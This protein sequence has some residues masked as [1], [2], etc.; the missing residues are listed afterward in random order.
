MTTL[1]DHAL[2]LAAA[3]F[4]V[5]PLEAGTKVP[6]IDAYPKRATR[7]PEQIRR[8][9]TCPVMGTL[10][11]Y[12]IGISTDRWQAPDGTI[13][14]PVVLDVDA[15]D[16]KPGHE[17]LLAHELAGRGSP[18]TWTGGTP[19]SGQHLFYL[20][21][22]P[23]TQGAEVL[24]PGLD[25]R[26]RG[27]YIVGPG[28][29]VTAGVYAALDNRAPVPAP[30]WVLAMCAPAR[31]RAPAQ[32]PAA[33]VDLERAM[34]RAVAY[35]ENEAPLALE[36]AGGDDTAYRVACRV[37][38]LGL[39]EPG[40]LEAMLDH[41]NDRCSPPWSPEELETK[42]A[43]AYRYGQEPVGA[44]APEAQFPPEPE[45]EGQEEETLSP[46]EALNREYAVCLVSGAHNVIRETTDE[47]GRFKL[48][49][50]VEPS[51]HKL[52]ATRP[53]MEIGGK[54][55]PLTKVWMT[56]PRRRTYEGVAFVPGRKARPGW[57]NLWR[58]FA[59]EPLR[60]GE[61]APAEW[62]AAVDMWLEH[63][64]E[65]I[66]QGNRQLFQWLIGW[67][68][69]IIQ[70]P[71]EKPQTALVLRGG[72]GT[73]KNVWIER[74]IKLLG[75]HGLVAADR[76]YLVGNFNAHLE[77]LLAFVLDEAFWSG[78]KAIEG[79]LKALVTGAT[80]LIERKGREPYVVDNLLRLI[81]LG[82]DDWLVQASVDER[83]WAAFSM[84]TKRQQDRAF[85][86]R[87]IS[88]MDAGG[89]RLLLRCL[90]DWK[91][92][93]DINVAPATKALVEQKLASLDP[94]H[95]WWLDSLEEGRIQG[96]DFAEG[97]QERMSTESVREAFRRYFRNRHIRSRLPEDRV[98]GKRLLEC[99]PAIR[100]ARGSTGYDYVLP[101]LDRAWA[102][103]K[104]FIG[105]DF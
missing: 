3:G 19:T 36:G 22:H 71:W 53:P 92:D 89:D 9:W 1:L 73:G 75:V 47:Q 43:N 84:G 86:G 14:C 11:P 59:V 76:R 48:D 8:W 17:T 13:H 33:E 5:F 29:E 12:N 42:V 49:Y 25:V 15:K 103:W 87:M 23:V 91:I 54:M 50:L 39:D 7:D 104:E 2:A 38:D 28:S 101:P 83:R 85:F 68:A 46:I 20:A 51:F 24:G 80:H 32:A 52:L 78:D 56:H 57:Y 66:C 26:A 18:R 44:A 90:L 35:L 63:A 10:R 100:R 41:W 79:I 81:I 96:S 82:N 21:P 64:Y 62:K 69:H 65:N 31:E 70:K 40:A 4:F 93:A 97:W 27:G 88:G 30:E 99:C 67:V 94:V 72:K 34:R 105:D 98:F 61:R 37:K 16:G 60:A 77:R 102:L 58:G 95:A 6:A 55:V 74:V 45:P